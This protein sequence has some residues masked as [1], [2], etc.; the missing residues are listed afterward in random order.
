M[1]CDCTLGGLS[2]NS[3]LGVFI[4]K[5]GME[6]ALCPLPELL[7]GQSCDPLRI[8]CKG[9]G[10]AADTDPPLPDLVCSSITLTRPAAF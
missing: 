5:P 6:G 10:P 9:H 8:D 3:E 1:C 4:W 7:V 2:S